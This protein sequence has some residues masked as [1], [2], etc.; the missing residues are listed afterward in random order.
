MSNKKAAAKKVNYLV[1]TEAFTAGATSPTPIL[2]QVV[3]ETETMY[4]TRE[5]FAIGLRD[6][7]PSRWKTGLVRWMKHTNRRPGDNGPLPNFTIKRALTDL[8]GVDPT[9]YLIVKA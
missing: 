8:D 1:V 3:R 7:L 2:L 5:F 4:F 9:K 6:L